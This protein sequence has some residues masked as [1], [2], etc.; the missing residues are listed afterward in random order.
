MDRHAF[1]NR[2]RS[3]YN[4]DKSVLDATLRKAGGDPLTWPEWER[5]RENPPR[6]FI[7]TDQPTADAI[8]ECVEA[9]QPKVRS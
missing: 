5:F 4:I 9:R 3:L 8:W 1:T 7:S 6:F 2:V